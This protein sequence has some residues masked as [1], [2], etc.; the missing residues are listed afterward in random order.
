VEILWP[1]II[2]IGQAGEATV[3]RADLGP[4]SL[5]GLKTNKARLRGSTT[6]A[7]QYAAMVAQFRAQPSPPGQWLEWVCRDSAAALCP[8]EAPLRLSPTAMA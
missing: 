8:G 2:I 3:F 7:T 6:S 4:G 5:A 1:V